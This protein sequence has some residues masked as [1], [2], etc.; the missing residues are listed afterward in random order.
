[1]L[2]KNQ[3]GLVADLH[4]GIAYLTSGDR[5]DSIVYSSVVCLARLPVL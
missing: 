2:P 3:Q 4:G 1:M 5:L